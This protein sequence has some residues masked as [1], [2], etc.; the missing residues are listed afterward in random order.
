MKSVMMFLPAFLSV[1]T[2]FAQ[3]TEA[4]KVR[5]GQAVCSPVNEGYYAVASAKEVQVFIN[6]T[7]DLSKFISVTA[8]NGV[9]VCCVKK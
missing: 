4:S 1:S 2:A 3:N 8:D 9:L 5:S 7:C 6:R